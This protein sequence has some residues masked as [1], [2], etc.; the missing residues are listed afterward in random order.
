M[1]LARA[2]LGVLTCFLA[3]GCEKVVD[4]SNATESNVARRNALVDSAFLYIDVR[5]RP[6]SALR[7]LEHLKPLCDPFPEQRARYNAILLELAW[8]TGNYED[9]IT[10]SI[11]SLYQAMVKGLRY[12][13]GNA[14]LSNIVGH[15]LRKSGDT[16]G[17][18]RYYQFM[19]S[20]EL[21]TTRKDAQ[22]NLLCLYS[23]T[24]NHEKAIEIAAQIEPQEL[25]HSSDISAHL[26]REFYWGRSLLLSG[27]TEPGIQHFRKVLAYLAAPRSNYNATEIRVRLSTARGILTDNV[28]KM[29]PTTIRKPLEAAVNNSIASDSSNLQMHFNTSEHHGGLQSIHIPTNLFALS[30]NTDRIFLASAIDNTAINQSVRDAYG[31]RWHATLLGLFIEVGQHFVRVELPDQ[32][33]I[34]RPVKSVRIHNDTL[35][36]ASYSGRLTQVPVDKLV[37]NYSRFKPHLDFFSATPSLTYGRVADN[38]DTL[39]LNDSTFLVGDSYGLMLHTTRS[40]RA[41]TFSIP[42]PNGI[43]DVMLALYK[44]GDSVIVCSRALGM[45]VIEQKKLLS[46]SRDFLQFE[47]L[48]ALRQMSLPSSA[49]SVAERQILGEYPPH[50]IALYD[51]LYPTTEQRIYVI[52]RKHIV[53]VRAN[54]M[55]AAS[56]TN[57]ELQLFA[58]PDS[59]V[60]SFERG[61]RTALVND[62]ILEIRSSKLNVTVNIA[63]LLARTLPGCLIAWTGHRN[64]AAQFAWL[65]SISQPVSCSD[66]L[67]FVL[68]ASS[69]LSNYLTTVSAEASWLPD[70]ISYAVSSMYNV[71]LP[72]TREC[73]LRLYS[74]GLVQTSSLLLQPEIHP[75]LYQD[76]VVILL[77]L[78]TG[79]VAIGIVYIWHRNAVRRR[80]DLEHQHSS[81]ARDLHDTLG[82]DLARLTAL[83]NAHEIQDSREIV[84]A[85]LAANRKFRS[86]LWIWRS[87]SIRLSDFTGELREYLHASLSDAQI[88]LTTT[89]TELPAN[90]FVDATVAKSVLLIIN[91]SLSN[92]IRHASSTNVTVDFISNQASFTV[93]VIDNGIGFNPSSVRRKSGI[94][95]IQERASENGFHADVISAEG[96]GTTVL[97][98][99]GVQLS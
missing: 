13:E 57:K 93:K 22:A 7:I 63:R 67:T 66:S 59:L 26:N 97:I 10:A 3:I 64:D 42:N 58:W 91:E 82:A 19:A 33:G 38:K 84:N 11:P 85:A 78:G 15:A 20:N 54:S 46:G 16:A 61:F 94:Q 1:G 30:P 71:A 28:I 9:V 68:G 52:Q 89:T 17:A 18:I 75:L 73:S 39:T 49:T 62:S 45:R 98:S 48:R 92:I 83:L 21:L 8:R 24:G 90:S 4:R 74:P 34:A 40:R 35:Y 31:V 27:K 81:I 72:Y 53:I 36:T 5:E 44:N 29:L 80:Q 87:D 56:T 60:A 76:V 65:S 70:T 32:Q 6:D 25:M 77:I 47:P 79:G 95:N 12:D 41:Q 50:S 55:I 96:T 51:G 37:A 69:L 88:K 43:Q 86:L 2:L 23:R 14:Q 99:F